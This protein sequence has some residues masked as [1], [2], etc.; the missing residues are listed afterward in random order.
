MKKRFKKKEENIFEGSINL[1]MVSERA[2][3]K[4]DL[5]E[6]QDQTTGMMPFI[7]RH[8]AAPILPSGYSPI[9]LENLDPHEQSDP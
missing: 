7:N 3:S 2:V 6:V 1:Q 4:S 8:I 5:I 9:F